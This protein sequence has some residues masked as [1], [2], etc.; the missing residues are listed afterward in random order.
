MINTLLIIGIICVMLLTDRVGGLR[1]PE[2]GMRFPLELRG[3][4]SR[5]RQLLRPATAAD[6][7]HSHNSRV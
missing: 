4:K 2:A 5:R 6:A 3:S 1:S 7:P